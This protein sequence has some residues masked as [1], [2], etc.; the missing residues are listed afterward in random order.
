MNKVYWGEKKVFEAQY[1]FDS[2]PA[3]EPTA[4]RVMECIFT[5]VNI[6]DKPIEG[7]VQE[8]DGKEMKI[9]QDDNRI[10]RIFNVILKYVERGE[11]GDTKIIFKA[12]PV[13]NGITSEII[14]LDWNWDSLEEK[15]FCSIVME[16][17][18][19]WLEEHEI[20][21]DAA[22]E[23]EFAKMLWNIK[24]EKEAEIREKYKEL[25]E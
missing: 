9:L 2:I 3:Q 14:S 16:K 24:R 6:A 12:Y 18:E 11:W 20:E 4:L 23:V 25:F 8:L 22:M 7:F 17:H 10:I 5:G 19:L 1:F 15:E 13:A 21:S